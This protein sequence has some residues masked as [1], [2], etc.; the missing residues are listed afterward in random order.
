VFHVQLRQFPHNHAQFNLSEDELAP[1]ADA[2]AS[3]RWISLGERKWS[4]HQAKLTIIEGPRIALAA[5]S[6]GR[7]W[8]QVEREGT[9]VTRRVLERASAVAQVSGGA[10]EER[11]PA[12]AKKGSGRSVGDAADAAAERSDLADKDVRD[13]LGEGAQ[14]RELLQAWRS[15]TARSPQLS[16]SERLALAE[17]QLRTA[18]ADRSA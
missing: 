18:R 10:G 1:I 14:A 12:A 7:G 2:W 8:R 13:L 4:P 9:D 6:M 15:V 16:P 5:L 11:P 3:D 17:L